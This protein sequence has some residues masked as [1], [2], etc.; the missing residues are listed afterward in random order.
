MRGVAVHVS[1][2]VKMVFLVAP[3]CI[4]EA[5]HTRSHWPS[6]RISRPVADGTP[7]ETQKIHMLTNVFH[8]Q[9]LQIVSI[10]VS[11]T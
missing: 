6:F 8:L 4:R 5:L 2:A 7:R 1:Q 10:A 9:P 11:E 3:F